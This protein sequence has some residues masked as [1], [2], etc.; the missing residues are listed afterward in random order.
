MKPHDSLPFK[1]QACQYSTVQFSSSCVLCCVV[2]CCITWYV[3]V[4]QE[5]IEKCLLRV[6]KQFVLEMCQPCTALIHFIILM[7]CIYIGVLDPF[8]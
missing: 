5:D 2:L 3:Q 7:C 1:S 4:P 8:K 6:N